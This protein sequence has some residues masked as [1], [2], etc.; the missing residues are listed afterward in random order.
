MHTAPNQSGTMPEARE[1]IPTPSPLSPS[2]DDWENWE[3]EDVVT[4]IEPAEQVQIQHPPTSDTAPRT[5][6][7]SMHHRVSKVSQ[8]RIRRLKSRHR[9][10]AQNA[11]AGIKLITD[12]AALRRQAPSA[13]QMR[14]SDGKQAKFVDAAALRALEGE[15]NSASVGNWNW[16]RRDKGKSPVSATPQSGRTPGTGL[17]PEDFPIMIGI[18]LPPEDV[19]GRDLETPQTANDASLAVPVLTSQNQTNEARPA[20]TGGRVGPENQQHVS[21]WSPDTP[22]PDTATT[23]TFRPASS[24]YSQA[25]TLL[26]PSTT[27]GDAPPV[28]ALPP[29]YKKMPHQRLI[30]LELGTNNAE[31][32]DSGTP[33]TLFEEDGLPTP[34]SGKP[35]AK[36]SY[37]SPDSAG[38]RSRGW[39]DHVVTPFAD[40]RFTFSTQKSKLDSPN[41]HSPAANR[42][43]PSLRPSIPTIPV[44]EKESMPALLAVPTAGPPPIVRAPT[45]RRTPSPQLDPSHNSSPDT[46]AERRASAFGSTDIASEKAQLT[47][48]T[49]DAVIDQPPPYSPPKKNLNSPGRFRALFP[50][51]HASH[52]QRSPSPGLGSPGLAATMT[53]QGHVMSEIP[54]TPTVP[55]DMP[56]PPTNPL[57]DR[58][59]GTFLPQEHSH[60][61]RGAE[62]RVE[63]ERRRHEKE[64]VIARRAGG[65]WRGRGCIP[66]TGCFG[67]TG[68][69]GRKK[70]RILL[71]VIAGAIALIVLVV[72]LAVVL[73]RPQ[74]PEEVPSIFVN[75][76]DF[77]PMPTGV[78]SIVGPDNTIARSG[79]TE[80]STLWS[81]SLPKDD[82]ESVGPYRANQPT[83]IMQIQWDNGTRKSWDVPNGE[84]P[85]TGERRAIG[86][87]ASAA[88]TIRNRETTKFSPK[89]DPPSFKEMWFLGDTT[90][91]IESEEKG[92]E[93]APF[94]ISLLRSMNDTAE[95]PILDKRQTTIGKEEFLKNIVSSPD[96]LDDGTPAPARLL[97][98]AVHQPVRLYDRGLPTEHYGFYTYFKKTIYL[99]SA[100]RSNETDEGEVPLDEDGGSRKTEA[101]FLATWSETRMLVQIWT[102]KLNSTQLL[103]PD[104][105]GGING[106]TELIRPGTMPYPVT[107]TVDT[108]GGT[109]DDKFLW[110][111]PMDERQKLDQE[112]PQFGAN[113]MTFGGSY[114]NPRSRGKES[115]GGFDGGTGGC[116]CEWKNWVN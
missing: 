73:T 28:P 10:K 43:Q 84:K 57:P 27:S 35:K 107:V 81:C 17:S 21:V 72:V 116:K 77:P 47:D 52:G 86:N 99:R 108:H 95:T 66:A 36:S 26:A 8:P 55:R 38:S 2:V 49:D 37:I 92:G 76:T 85:F 58:P 39:W 63:R 44:S 69:E 64:D 97:P 101:N 79:C 24:I 18:S 112:N 22:T 70:R 14:P 59:I 46:I 32:D 96:L 30:S 87:A 74:A 31:E 94:Y 115:L 90:D 75:L 80:P 7:K 1:T 56:S 20:Q 62:N 68:R 33:C 45:P 12:M 61:A 50:P 11:K 104:N 29:T 103:N 48:G 60:D 54:I 65:F 4:P 109:P 67:R 71:G 42:E 15:P 53:S 106:T 82:H 6:T 5:N 23:I 9:Q 34:Q 3:D 111:W 88:G 102:R 16:L 78:L 19:N 110:I 105:R 41:D 113:V 98:D 40:T 91:G 89:P 114:I 13:Q 83:I 51:G 93:P 25:T 100:S